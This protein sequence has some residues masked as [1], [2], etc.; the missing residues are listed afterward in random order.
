M[1]AESPHPVHVK[2]S[3]FSGGPVAQSFSLPDG[4]C[5]PKGDSPSSLSL[6]RRPLHL[7]VPG[8]ASTYPV[9]AG[10]VFST[11]DGHAPGRLFAWPSPS[12]GPGSMDNGPCYS[13]SSTSV[14]NNALMFCNMNT[15]ISPDACSSAGSTFSPAVPMDDLHM[16]TPASDISPVEPEG[17]TQFPTPPIAPRRGPSVSAIPDLF[18][19]EGVPPALDEPPHHVQTRGQQQIYSSNMQKMDEPYAKLI[20]RAFMSRP[21]YS[22]TLQDLYQWFRENTNKAVNEKGGWQNSIRHNLS[23][24]GVSLTLWLYFFCTGLRR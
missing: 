12:L 7:Q 11:N 3:D 2:L 5:T 23:M 8:S 14:P 4:R 21:D 22:M 19:P 1:K 6:T 20:Y 16:C 10:S 18:S 15:P 9:S 17:Q 24:N 13:I